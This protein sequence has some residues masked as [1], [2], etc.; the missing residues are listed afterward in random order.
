[1]CTNQKCV[2]TSNKAFLHVITVYLYY[3]SKEKEPIPN[4]PE[5]DI[6]LEFERGGFAKCYIFCEVI[7]K[8]KIYAQVIGVQESAF[9]TTLLFFLNC[10]LRV[11]INS[12]FNILQSD[13]SQWL[14][15]QVTRHGQ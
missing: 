11:T 10:T 15:N 6:G 1:M 9:V 8:P 12:T 3:D 13:R 2:L 14:S 7:F 4:R 5:L